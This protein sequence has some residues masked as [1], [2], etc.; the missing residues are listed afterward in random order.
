[1]DMSSILGQKN[2]K[3]FYKKHLTKSPPYDIIESRRCA[4][5]VLAFAPKK[6]VTYLK[7]KSGR[8]PFGNE[9]S[10][11]LTNYTSTPIPRENYPQN[12]KPINRKKQKK[13]ANFVCFLNYRTHIILL[14]S[15]F[16]EDAKIPPT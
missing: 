11:F 14:I 3:F 16:L 4:A 7:M 1:M 10:R 9:P 15:I 13:E 8:V 6:S 12:R 5:K 2:K